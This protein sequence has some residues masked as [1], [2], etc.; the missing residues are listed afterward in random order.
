M[1]KICRFLINIIQETHTSNNSQQTFGPYSTFFYYN[2][3]NKCGAIGQKWK[4]KSEIVD[5][6]STYIE[7]KFLQLYFV[8]SKKAEIRD[9]LIPYLSFPLRRNIKTTVS[10]QRSTY[11]SRSW[12]QSKTCVNM[13]ATRLFGVCGL[14][15]PHVLFSAFSS[16]P[17]FLGVCSCPAPSA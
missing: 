15:F 9:T 14:M 12:T 4:Y 3:Y 2:R 11:S 17:K 8:K 10:F 7:T 1:R 5:F 16:C 13:L 6:N